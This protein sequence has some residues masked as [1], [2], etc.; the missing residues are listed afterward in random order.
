MNA[1]GHIFR[2]IQEKPEKVALKVLSGPS[3]T[4]SDLGRLSSVILLKRSALN[5]SIGLSALAKYLY[6]L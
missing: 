2:Q 3:A 1:A 5:S 4:F 6:E